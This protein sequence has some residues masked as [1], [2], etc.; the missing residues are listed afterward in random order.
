MFTSQSMIAFS[1]LDGSGKSTQIALLVNFFKAE[2]IKT[3]VFWSRGGYTPGMRLLKVILRNLNSPFIP[4]RSG[5]SVERDASFANKYIRKI[6]LTLSIL[7][8]IIFYSVYIRCVEFFGIRV[9]CDRYLYDTEI[10]F[11]RSF[12]DENV[13]QWILWKFLEFVSVTP[14]MHFVLFIS[15]QESQHRSILKKEPFPDSAETLAFRLMEYKKYIKMDDSVVGINC[16]VQMS[17]IHRKI[18]SSISQ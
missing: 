11:K 18:I 14:K 5:N 13:H 2:N 9:I 12:P 17:Y 16:E 3:K 8:L 7:D 6:W 4:K 10:D 1:G 15:V